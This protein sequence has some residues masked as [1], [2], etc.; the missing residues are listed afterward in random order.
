MLRFWV[1]SCTWL[2][3]STRLIV[4]AVI[5]WF[6]QVLTQLPNSSPALPFWNFWE[7]PL[8]PPVGLEALVQGRALSSATAVTMPPIRTSRM[9]ME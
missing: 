2:L 1:N 9:A 6:S 3:Q 8:T 4:S 7:R 5:A